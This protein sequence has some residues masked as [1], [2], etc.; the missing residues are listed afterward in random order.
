MERF[1]REANTVDVAV[2]MHPKLLNRLNEHLFKLGEKN[3]SGWIRAA[4]I[5]KMNREL[6]AMRDPEE[7]VY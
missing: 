6:E 2:S 7:T 3:R 4:I 1:G 5:S